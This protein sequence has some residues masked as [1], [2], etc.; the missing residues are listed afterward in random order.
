ME[1][2]LG[3]SPSPLR[4]SPLR[5]GTSGD[6]PP[7]SAWPEGA[8]LP[9]GFS[10][11]LARAFARDEGLEIQWVRFRWP[12]LLRDLTAG[13][14]D[15]AL[16]GVTIRPERA[17]AGLSSI[18]LATS[19]ALVLMPLAQP[20]TPD[21]AHGLL[22]DPGLRLAVN[23]GGHLERVTRSRFPHAIVEAI[24][25]NAAV[26]R[27]LA[28]GG[29]DGVVTDLV[30]A[31]LWQARWQTEWETRRR[32][33]RNEERPGA[34]WSLHRIGPFTRD[35]K[36]GLW[37]P[38]RSELARR[39]D[40]WL[41]AAEATGRL[42]ALRRQHGLPTERTG[43][44]GAALLVRLDER[45]SLMPAVARAKA[46]LGQPI[47]DRAREARVLAAARRSVVQ[48]A[49]RA[50]LDAPGEPGI[51]EL[52]RAQ[53]E[54][55]RWIQLR[56]LDAPPIPTTSAPPA[57]APGGASPVPSISAGASAEAARTELERVLRPALIRIGDRLA[58]L[59]VAWIADPD[60]VL[61]PERVARALERHA[62]PAPMIER[63]A[64]ALQAL[65]TDAA[66][67][68]SRRRPPTAGSGRVPSA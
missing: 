11:D 6:Y 59:L 62:L 26:L 36:A 22:A 42:D 15:L 10:V 51:D 18:P 44:P 2:E 66:A 9:R 8:A 55:A 28:S 64:A 17:A 53:M 5:I 31:P 7:F 50:G 12:D 45:L 63:L 60:A 23:A 56:E 1:P 68:A 29:A 46:I 33:E 43:E 4:N 52:F 61:A 3:S 30:E 48:A 57:P 19:G 35:H 58:D 37:R 16:S 39:F 38:D 21:L 20:P 32:A 49:R 24:P 13:R 40:R 14:F 67:D 41:L 54:A 25:D 65:R 34:R 47:E 27:R